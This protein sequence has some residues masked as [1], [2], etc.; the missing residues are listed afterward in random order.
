MIVV[1]LL[2]WLQ[3]CNWPV[4]RVL[5][6]FLA[7]VGTPL[8]PYLRPILAGDDAIWKYWIIVAVLADAPPD[9]LQALRP[10]LERL[11]SAPTAREVEEEIPEPARAALDRAATV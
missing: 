7:S 5:A 9:V 3:D 4:S 8:V 11:V 2:E 10:E 1:E 6:P